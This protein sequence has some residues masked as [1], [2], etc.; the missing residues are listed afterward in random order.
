MAALDLSFAWARDT[1]ATQSARPSYRFACA[2]PSSESVIPVDGS[3][4]KGWAWPVET[5]ELAASWPYALSPARPS[6]E[7][8]QLRLRSVLSRRTCA[9]ELSLTRGSGGHTNGWW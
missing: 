9:A 5:L 1:R 3:G 4:W 6:G 2:K 8:S 7:A